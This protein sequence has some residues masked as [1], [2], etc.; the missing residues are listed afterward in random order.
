ML[1]IIFFT[2]GVLSAKLFNAETIICLEAYT[3]LADIFIVIL[4]MHD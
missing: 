4:D 2:Y 3:L 1:C